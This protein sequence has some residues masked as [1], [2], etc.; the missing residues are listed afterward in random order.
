MSKRSRALDPARRRRSLNDMLLSSLG[1]RI[2]V[3]RVP[4]AW[5]DVA[6][7]IF[8]RKARPLSAA[9]EHGQTVWVQVK[10]LA[11]EPCRICPNLPGEVHAT[12]PLKSAATRLRTGAE[13]RRE[14]I[15]YTG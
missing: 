15:L 14:A 8:A 9:R 5:P 10:S 13:T 6:I 12:V 3:F 7:R 11:G 1:D 2:R 4:S